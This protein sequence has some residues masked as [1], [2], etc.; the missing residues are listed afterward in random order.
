MDVS[1]RA[2]L[3]KSGAL[4]CGAAV[5]VAGASQAKAGPL[6]H[7][8]DAKQRFAMVM[9]LRKCIGCQACTVACSMENQIPVGDFRTIVSQYDVLD[10]ASG[11]VE[12]FTLPRMCNHC[13][14]PPC[15]PVCPVQATYQQKDGKV[16]IDAEK[17][18]GC[19]Y[20]VQAC[21]YDARYINPVTNTADKCTFCTHRVEAGLLPACVETCT[22]GARNFGDIKDPDSK[23]SKLLA[24]HKDDIKV[25]RP[26]METSP[27]V[28]YI[29]L[30]PRFEGR[31]KGEAALWVG[32]ETEEEN[33]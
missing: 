15:V 26:E 18:V 21:P 33:S 17:C 10:T 9:D 16:L 27:H 32:K 25:L 14:N 31:V 12:S 3:K 7:G 23:V 24:E 4:T 2:F 22:G 30:D 28:F 29:G 8:G 1:R 5:T 20:C 19:G 13:D 11:A 6:R